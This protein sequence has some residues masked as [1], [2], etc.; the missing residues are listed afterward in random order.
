MY[1]ESCLSDPETVNPAC[2]EMW[3][4]GPMAVPPMPEKKMCI[5]SV[6]HANQLAGP[7][8]LQPLKGTL[9]VPSASPWRMLTLSGWEVKACPAG[10][11]CF[12]ISGSSNCYNRSYMHK[13]KLHHLLVMLRPVSYWYFIAV[14]V[15][16]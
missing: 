5:Q 8:R 12:F 1:C 6:Y 4:R 2:W 10:V 11:A 3:A 13:R 7:P 9:W 16:S 15:V 14:F